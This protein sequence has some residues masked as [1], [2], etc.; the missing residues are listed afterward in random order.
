MKIEIDNHGFLC[1][2]HPEIPQVKQ[3]TNVVSGYQFSDWDKG[4]IV[5]HK[6][7]FKVLSLKNF[8]EGMNIVYIKDKKIE[9]WDVQQNLLG[10]AYGLF[11]A[12]DEVSGEQKYFW[13]G[14]R[15]DPSNILPAPCTWEFSSPQD[16]LSFL[17]GLTLFCME[18]LNPSR[19]NS[20]P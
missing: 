7:E 2:H 15:R 18:N 19:E 17:Y 4:I 20:C 10:Q 14:A 12:F 11:S 16:I 5:L 3:Y 1:I 13:P 9:I 8:G 6:K